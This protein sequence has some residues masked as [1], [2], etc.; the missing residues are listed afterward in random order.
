MTQIVA[1]AAMATATVP[2]IRAML[3]Y[4]LSKDYAEGVLGIRARPDLGC[5]ES[6]THKGR[7]VQVVPCVSALAVREALLDRAPH[8]WLVV[9]TD[10]ADEDLGAGI[11]SH[12]L[13][14]RLRTPDPWEAAR[15]RFAATGIDPALTSLTG[16]RDIATGLLTGA[17]IGGWPPAPAGVLTRDHA[18]GAVARAHLGL[19]GDH[20]DALGAL[21]WTTD[22]STVVRIADLRGQVG[23][24]LTDAVLDWVADGAGAI[25]EPLRRLL[26]QGEGSDAV[27]LGIVAG[28]L[29]D[30]LGRTV[31]DDAQVGRMALVRL[32]QRWG[33]PPP[34]EAI[35]RSWGMT[36]SSVLVRLLARPATQPSAER[37]LGRAYEIIRSAQAGRA[38]RALPAPSCWSD[39]AAPGFGRCLANIGFSITLG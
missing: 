13:W 32:E 33:A 6:F 12:F 27:S 22:P 31:G 26:R 39:G 5:A 10:R 11:L 19:G 17:P 34:S 21:E 29:A 1:S 4:A 24:A 23:D 2:V 14:H 37:L 28:L 20:L 16:N 3:D 7:Q 30:A 36:S 25:A 8:S 18:L 9:L 38:G 35:L 15:L